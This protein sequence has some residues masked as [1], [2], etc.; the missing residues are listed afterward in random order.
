MFRLTAKAYSKLSDE[1]RR[2][3]GDD[4]LMRAQRE[5]VLKRLLVMRDRVGPLLT[6]AEI[7]EL[8]LDLL[9]G[10]NPAVIRQAASLNRPV[11]PARKIV[12]GTLIGAGTI[13]LG[14]G[15]IAFLNLPYPMIRWP[16]AKVMPIILLPSFMEMD[17]NYR[18]VVSLVEQSDQLVN[19]A[20]SAADIKLGAQKVDAA[21]KSLDKLPV[22][23]LGYYPQMYCQWMTCSWQFT[24]DEFLQARQKIGRMDA[25]I[26]QED[27]AMTTFQSA[28]DWL[29]TAKASY[30]KL[31]QPA[32]IGDWQRAIDQLEQLPQSTLAYRLANTKLDA[33]QRDFKSATSVALGQRQA[34]T[35]LDIAKAYATTASA[36][37]QNPPHPSEVWERAAKQWELAIDRLEQ[38]EPDNPGYGEAQ[39]LKATYQG[40]LGT[41]ELRFKQEELS[42]QSLKTAEALYSEL[43]SQQ[44][45]SIPKGVL[46]STSQK[47]L[48]VLQDVRSGSTA[49]A[50]ANDLKKAVLKLLK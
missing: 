28:E 14:A 21:Q 35:M 48:D 18:Q 4:P 24:K 7:K 10:C 46:H 34:N 5:I 2:L 36:A 20:T 13:G 26:F 30:L 9:P 43:L 29:T 44:G 3:T 22:W 40:S 8:I 47:I 19:Q 23:F 16:V 49:E 6:E 42:R 31:K 37:S 27:Q 32:A 12:A 39:I 11:G 15:L 25:K 38:V 1:V 33:Y 45:Q 50:K 17:H 41:V